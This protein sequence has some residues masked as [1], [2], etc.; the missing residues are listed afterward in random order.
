MITLPK[1]PVNRALYNKLNQI[2]METNKRLCEIWSKDYIAT[3]PVQI[4][5]RGFDYS[6]NESQKDILI[7]GINPSFNPQERPNKS[8]KFSDILF[9]RVPQ[10]RYWNPIKKMLLDANYDFRAESAYLDLF[11]FREQDQNFLRHDIL[12]NPMGIPFI[13]DQLNLTQHIIEDVIRP[14]CIIIAN[15]E[16]AAYWGKLANEGIIW[17]GYNLQFIKR[18]KTGDLYRVTGLLNSSQRIGPEFKDTNIKDS[19][20]LFSQHINQFTPSEKR[21]TAQTIKVLLDYYTA[22]EQLKNL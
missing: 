9:D 11:Y 6:E 2:H 12:T 1:F 21:P 18:L 8:F 22:T 10:S 20:I 13:V 15:K 19:L 17:M 4:K 14:K 3:L 7:T 5:D 16:S